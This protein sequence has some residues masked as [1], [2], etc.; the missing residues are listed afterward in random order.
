MKKIFSF[1]QDNFKSRLHRM[2]VMNTPIAIYYTWKIIK[3]FLD[4]VTVQKIRFSKENFDDE[5]WTHINKNQ[6][7]EKFGGNAKTLEDNFWF[8][9]LKIFSDLF[10]PPRERSNEYLLEN[11][12]P[13]LL[14]STV[15]EYRKRYQA[16]E[17]DEYKVCKELVE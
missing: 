15:E 8:L 11:D 14:L 16:E 5:M 12:R 9:C 4:E 3:G 1:L 13:N 10:R 6:V 7:E 2:Y 17:L